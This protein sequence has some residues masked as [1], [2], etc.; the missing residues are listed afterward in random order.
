MPPHHNVVLPGHDKVPDGR[1]LRLREGPGPGVGLHAGQLGAAHHVERAHV[2]PVEA[3]VP[4]EVD[5]GAVG[6]EAGEGGG[7][8]GAVL[9]PQAVS[10]V[11]VLIAGK[12]NRFACNAISVCL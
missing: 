5:A 7:G 12:E 3:E 9:A 10:A 4:V 8:A 1:C 11:G 2:A 6:E